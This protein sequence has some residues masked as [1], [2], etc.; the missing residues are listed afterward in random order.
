MLEKGKLAFD[1]KKYLKEDL[2]ATQKVFEKLLTF[3]PLGMKVY[4]TDKQILIH[5]LDIQKRGLPINK[6][7]TQNL[8]NKYLVV[9]RETEEFFRKRYNININSPI[10]IAKKFGLENA[11]KSTLIK[12][13]FET[14]DDEKRKP[15]EI[16]L[17]YKKK[18][19]L[20]EFLKR[21]L[22]KAN[23][24]NRVYGYFHPC[25]ALSGR[26][27]CSDE[28]LLQVPRDL[29]KIFQTDKWFLLYDF[30]QIELR[31][32]GQMWKDPLFVRAFQNEEDLHYLTSQTLFQKLEISKEE[33]QI[34]KIFNFA[35]LYG[36][37][38]KTLYEILL[39]AGLNYNL[40][41]I[42]NFRYAWL[43]LYK[44]IKKHQY[45]IKT[46]L[47]TH[48]K[49]IIETALGRSILAKNF[50]DALNFPIQGSGADLLKGVV[51]KF[52]R[53]FPEARIINLVH[54][55]IQI[56]CETEEE[57]KE[58]AKALDE[59]LKETWEILFQEVFVPVKGEYSIQN[60][61][62]K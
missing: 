51:I 52:L 14:E 27:S 34:G 16:I 10:Q 32:A 57:A 12:F 46:Y 39:D 20:V 50:S 49:I 38:V 26:L 59:N 43:N 15:I 33:R 24:G 61:L 23:S 13:L 4:A 19:K 30:S 41:T 1:L 40:E 29:R 36:A 56:E 7:E 62:A 35:M 28:N 54:D 18:V 37:G 6:E 3:F 31:L 53:K 60:F 2:E 11:Q 44:T 25:G 42:K 17:D 21:F 55:E 9:V 8:L 5:L 22:K 48:G 58:Y 47:E 45:E